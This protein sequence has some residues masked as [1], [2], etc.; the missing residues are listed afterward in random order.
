MCFKHKR[1]AYNDPK[2]KK[3]T[4][5]LLA[6]GNR[7]G[8]SSSGSAPGSLWAPGWNLAGRLSGSHLVHLRLISPD[9]RGESGSEPRWSCCTCWH[10]RA[11]NPH[12]VADC[13]GLDRLNQGLAPAPQLSLC[14]LRCPS[15]QRHSCPV[16]HAADPHCWLRPFQQQHTEA[17]IAA[18]VGAQTFWLL[19][20]LQH[21]RSAFWYGA[22]PL[23]SSALECYARHLTVTGCF[24][25]GQKRLSIGFPWWLAIMASSY[26]LFLHFS[27]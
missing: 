8:F 5:G 9:M 16:W 20:F 7:R 25:S 3:G 26:F 17:R 22:F 19:T 13:E 27:S 10:T 11:R 4:E 23:P 12:L 24:K 21:P 1:D 2:L 15:C 6:P 18:K 14:H